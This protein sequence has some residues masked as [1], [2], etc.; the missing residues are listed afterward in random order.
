MILEIGEVSGSDYIED[1][2]KERDFNLKLA[3]ESPQ[4]KRSRMK[5][6]RE[7]DREKFKYSDK[8]KE[9]KLSQ[10]KAIMKNRIDST[11]SEREAV[12]SKSSLR[13]FSNGEDVQV[14]SSKVTA[15]AQKLKAQLNL[16][17]K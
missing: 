2:F 4:L 10:I 9:E 17:G 8:E 11:S 6:A 1:T 12:P 3:E 5:F 13:H 16:D 7:I 15:L 14:Q